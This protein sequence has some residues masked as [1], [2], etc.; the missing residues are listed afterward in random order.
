MKDETRTWGSLS[1]LQE[2]H[3]RSPIDTGVKRGLNVGGPGQG[4]LIGAS[5]YGN[6][7]I[8]PRQGILI[9]SIGYVWT[10]I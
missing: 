1:T 7:Q 3:I 2:E 4:E 6:D 9:W 5:N 10:W 8:A